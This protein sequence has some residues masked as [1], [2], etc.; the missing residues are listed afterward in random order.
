MNSNLAKFIEID[1]VIGLILKFLFEGVI[2]LG[3]GERQEA[4]K[5]RLV[6]RK[7]KNVF[8]RLVH[9]SITVPIRNR[10]KC[11]C[12]LNE[13]SSISMN[14]KY[15]KCKITK[16]VWEDI[17]GD[18]LN[19]VASSL[20]YLHINAGAVTYL[21]KFKC[22][23]SILWEVDGCYYEL[24]EDIPHKELII[25][26][27]HFCDGSIAHFTRL[28]EIEV[29]MCSDDHK[30]IDN[31]LPPT[32]L[33]MTIVVWPDVVDVIDLSKFGS[34]EYLEIVSG[35]KYGEY[36]IEELILPPTLYEF[37]SDVRIKKMNLHECKNLGVLELKFRSRWDITV[38]YLPNLYDLRVDSYGGSYSIDT[39]TLTEIESLTVGVIPQ[40][41][42]QWSVKFD[43]SDIYIKTNYAIS[44]IP[45]CKNLVE[46][47]MEINNEIEFDGT[48][49]RI[50]Y[51][52]NYYYR[53]YDIKNFIMV[54][55]IK[56][57][58][59]DYITGVGFD[60]IEVVIKLHRE[61]DYIDIDADELNIIYEKNN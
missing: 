52:R 17:F 13:I 48:E 53:D 59:L 11:N 26:K 32:I 31:Y 19:N 55:D 40:R 3:R 50:D 36:L 58:Y 61:I 29:I 28:R 21:P 34:L 12:P 25:N 20:E 6:C 49:E 30:F 56:N 39:R 23:E 24:L 47:A 37:Y 60:G 10:R 22:L 18:K 42:A 14:I 9:L 46:L 35:S 1:S 54:L 15:S 16:Q 33:C 27:Y 45:V 8:D 57:E 44:L 51:Y 38:P 5:F 2:E 43:G 41:D 7:F 4:L